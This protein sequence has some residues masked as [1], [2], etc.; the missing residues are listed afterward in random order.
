MGMDLES[1]AK[2]L[3]CSSKDDIITIKAEDQA[4]KVNFVFESPNQE[5]V[6]EYEMKLMNIEEE[7]LGIPDTDYAAIIK[8]PSLEFHVW[9]VISLSLGNLWSFPAPR[10]EFNFLSKEILAM[11]T[12]NLLRLPMWIRKKKLL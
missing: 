10:K 3:R 6:S 2:I 9:F 11:V 1:M 12:S 7:H 8:M 4:D 5:K